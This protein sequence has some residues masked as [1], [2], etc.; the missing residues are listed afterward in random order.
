MH[1]CMDGWGG[2]L[3]GGRGFYATHQVVA[4]DRN[5]A[6]CSGAQHANMGISA[7]T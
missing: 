1:A 7:T 4:E 6:K 3:L 2:S 5:T